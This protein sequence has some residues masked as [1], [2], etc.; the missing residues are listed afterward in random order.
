MHL[1]VAF[2]RTDALKWFEGLP[3]R[4]WMAHGV[5]GRP[6]A[7]SQMPPNRPQDAF[8]APQ[9]VLKMP[10][11]RPKTS[12]RCPQDAPKI[13][14]D[15]PEA[16]PRQPQD[17]QEQFFTHFGRFCDLGV[18]VG[19]ICHNFGSGL[20]IFLHKL[21]ITQAHSTSKDEKLTASAVAGTQLCAL[22][23]LYYRL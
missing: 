13:P 15:S 7:V 11:S 10:P 19:R 6:R 1:E 20:A 8:T 4:L 9:D 14:K 22:D 17:A 16:T 5:P 2:S 12:P 18:I 23:R 21:D 3:G